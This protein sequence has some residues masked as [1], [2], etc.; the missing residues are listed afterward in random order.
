MK[1]EE[2]S[3]AVLIGRAFDGHRWSEDDGLVVFCDKVVLLNG[4]QKSGDRNEDK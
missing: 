4:K 3:T 2:I 1:Q